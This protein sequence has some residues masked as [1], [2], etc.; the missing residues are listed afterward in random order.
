MLE[1]FEGIVKENSHIL[2]AL[3]GGPDSMYLLYLLK[4]ARDEIPFDLQ[5]AHLHHGLRE[6]A[7]RDLAF[8]ER[9]CDAWSIPLVTKRVDV[10]AVAREKKCG[11]EEAGRIVRYAFFRRH[12]VPGGL[13][14]L[15]HHL[16]DQV[17]T[18]L[19][20]L[21][22]GT[23]LRGME[24]MKVLEGDI[25]R[26]LLSMTKDEILREL[27]KNRIPYVVDE[28][29]LETTYSRNRV[30]W[31]IVP[32]AERI[33][34]RFQRVMESF[35]AMAREDEDYLSQRSEELYDRLA[36]KRRD[37][38]QL[39]DAV[40][41]AP[42]AVRRRV[43]RR[44]I[45]QVKGSVKNIG[46]DHIRSID[47]LQKAETGTGIDLPGVR[48]ERSYGRVAF[49][50]KESLQK[51]EEE[52]TLQDGA[53]E[54]FGHRFY[55]GDGEE[56]VYVKDPAAVRIRTRRAGDV[57]ALKVGHKKLKDLFID[58]KIDRRLRDSWPVVLEGEQVIWVV[59]LRKAYRQEEK[60]WQKL[61]WIPSKKM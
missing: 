8:V 1:L 17:E 52:V 46:Y 13:I 27:E 32:E 12:K 53:A 56:F 42:D 19:L 2:V 55:I 54:F 16:D 5:A 22:R 51:T 40:Y 14:A 25:F 36:K 58:E 60:T 43:F 45:E 39:D 41:D 29:N 35:S 4:N 21:I 18:M 50:I 6:T 44:A 15:A 10:P 34:P 3:S 59:G 24:G 33:N 9:V 20:R 28:T 23:G 37:G 31:N 61:A 11:T 47:M 26:P 48:V 57:I 30:R 7:D 38:V 49:T